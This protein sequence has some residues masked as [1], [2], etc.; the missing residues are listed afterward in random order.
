MDE[1]SEFLLLTV[2]DGGHFGLYALENSARLFKRR[3]GAFFLQ[4][5]QATQ[6][7]RQTLFAEGWSRNHGFG[8]YY[9][10]ARYIFFYIVRYATMVN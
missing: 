3:V 9:D 1:I 2:T 6:N 5:L 8:P 7:N 4:I 10:L